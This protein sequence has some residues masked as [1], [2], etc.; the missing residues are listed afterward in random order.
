MEASASHQELPLQHFH[1]WCSQ[2]NP[3][4]GGFPQENP[5]LVAF[6]VQSTEV[7]TL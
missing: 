4:R 2:N 1:F 7:N 5:N 3:S 6:P